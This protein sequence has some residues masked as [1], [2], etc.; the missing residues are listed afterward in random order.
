MRNYGRNQVLLF[1]I[2]SLTPPL[3]ADEGAHHRK[4][5][6]RRFSLQTCPST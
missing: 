4:K 6:F 1:L 3:E 5:E 2:R